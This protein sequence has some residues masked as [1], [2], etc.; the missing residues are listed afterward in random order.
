MKQFLRLTAVAPVAAA[1]VC[2]GLLAASSAFAQQSSSS[3][4]DQPYT[5]VSNPPSQPIL[6][7]EQ[8]NPS[9]PPSQ[10]KPSPA[11]P[12]N[13]TA[14][15]PA[16]P[17]YTPPAPAYNSAGTPTA[18]PAVRNGNSDR[19]DNTDFG[20]V[21]KLPDQR[22]TRQ[23]QQ[24][25]SRSEGAN[26]DPSFGVVSVV[27]FTPGALN[28]GTNI[29]VRL[30][31]PLSTSTTPQDTPFRATVVSP[32]YRGSQ[33]VIPAGSELR[34]IVTDVHPGRHLVSRATLRLTPRLI[35]LPD[36]KAYHLDAEAVYTSANRT[37]TTDEGAFQPKMHLA[38]D[39][40]EYGA[41]AGLGAVAGAQ[42]GPGG[43]LIGTLVGAGAVS[44]HMLLQPP[45]ALTLPRNAEVIFSL[46][47]PMHLTPTRE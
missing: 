19:Y 20:I 16:Q 39:S 45:A 33:L 6:A 29:T 34:G 9:P 10:T 7:T 15:T 31:Q 12:K 18:Q 43:A 27:P 38:K 4:N 1:L 11:V 36:G 28:A 47:Q 32:V 23:V 14:S 13:Q 44:A 17:A 42:F 22:A 24:L 46:T 30:L 25:N 26:S 35:L 8:D 40:A 37:H 41:G 2:A 5:G 3:Q 21:T